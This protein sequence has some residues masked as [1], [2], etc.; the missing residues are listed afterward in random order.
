MAQHTHSH[1]DPACLEVFARLSEYLD[2]ELPDFE[3]KD[4]EQHISDC[5]PC[6]DFLRSLRKCIAA[7]RDFQ[8][9]EDCPPLPPEIAEKLKAAWQAALH[10]KTGL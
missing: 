5:P 1:K 6:V 10:R 7:S 9:G 2:G 8:G 4:I 3:C